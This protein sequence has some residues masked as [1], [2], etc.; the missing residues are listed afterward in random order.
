MKDSDPRP[1]PPE[2]ARA[3][4]RN[5]DYYD[6]VLL[7]MFKGKRNSVVET[8]VKLLVK[9]YGEVWALGNQTE[10]TVSSIVLDE[11]STLVAIRMLRA[12]EEYGPERVDA[13]LAEAM[14]PTWH[15]WWR[16]LSG[17]SMQGEE[18]PWIYYAYKVLG[19]RQIIWIVSQCARSVVDSVVPRLKGSC[20]HA[21]EAA[22][23]W[24]VDPSAHNATMAARAA[25]TDEIDDDAPYSYM[26][27]AAFAAFYAAYSPMDMYLFPMR[28]RQCMT[29]VVNSIVGRDPTLTE[30]EAWNRLA[31]IM[32]KLITPTLIHRPSGRAPSAGGRLGSQVAPL[33]VGAAIGAAAARILKK[34]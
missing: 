23:R 7:P 25:R 28:P 24:C 26:S 29:C 5:I 12:T 4:N 33:V 34:P 11:P 15:E 10:A 6:L 21:I 8:A 20:L 19:D 18:S 16:G 32:K 30:T 3:Y 13:A 1:M 14:Q 22:E 27:N 31:A 2:V 9:H 17:E